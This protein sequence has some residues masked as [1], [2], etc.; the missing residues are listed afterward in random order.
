VWFLWSLALRNRAV[1]DRAFLARLERPAL[2]LAIVLAGW[3]SFHYSTAVWNGYGRPCWDEYGRYAS[4]VHAWLFSDDPRAGPSL[5]RFMRGDYHSNSPLVPVLVALVMKLNLEMIVGF[6]LACGLATVASVLVLW[7]TMTSLDRDREAACAA[8]LLL[9]TNRAVAR[10]FVFPQTDAFTL[11][12]GALLLHACIRRLQRPGLAS[13]IYLTTVLTLGLF[14]KLSLLPMLAA[15][16]LWWAL[17]SFRRI[18][19]SSA[20]PGAPLPWMTLGGTAAVTVL[21]VSVYLAFQR[22]L[23]T[24]DLYLR[25]IGMISSTQDAYV[26]FVLVACLLSC[27]AFLVLLSI[28]RPEWSE[29]DLLVAAWIALYVAS[30][31][32]SR[33]SGWNRFYLPVLPAFALLAVKGLARMRTEAGAGAM[34]CFVAGVAALNYAALHMDLY[35]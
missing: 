3:A 2:L 28:S 31:W 9:W 13:G 20:S 15:P 30:L 19:R 6:R 25:E 10:S 16:L 22:W 17:A 32:L 8:L 26:P 34:W 27:G 4:L 23:G 18:P 12:F 14:V 1:L 21:P 33:A 7:R 29:V 24:S 11:L 35:M 5:L